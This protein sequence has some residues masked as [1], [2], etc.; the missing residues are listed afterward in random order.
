MRYRFIDEHKKAWPVTLMCG[1]LGVS[2][3]GY[4]HWTTRELS[5]SK[6]ANVVLD[7][8]IREMFAAHRQRYGTPRITE[9]LHDEGITCSKNRVAQRMSVHGTESDAGKE[10]R[11]FP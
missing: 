2:R 1:V 11:L 9:A 7:R 6:L 8:Q 4:Y 3:S 5:R 10:I